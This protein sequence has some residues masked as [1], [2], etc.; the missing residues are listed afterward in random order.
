[1]LFHLWRISMSTNPR[2]VKFDSCQGSAYVV[3]DF[4]CN[5]SALLLNGGLEMFCQCSQL[6][7]RLCEA[8]NRQCTLFL[9]M[10]NFQCSCRDV[11]EA[12]YVIFQKVI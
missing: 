9:G 6:C 10:M 7:L 8:T 5:A 4:P 3:V 2:D 1:M 12:S 11:G